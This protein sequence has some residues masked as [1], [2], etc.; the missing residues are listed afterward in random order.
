MQPI[1]LAC[2]ECDLLQRRPAL[3]TGDDAR[4]RRC[5]A[6][7]YRARNDNLDRP[8]AFTF[9]AALLFAVA[10]AFPIVSLEVQ[11]LT[12]TAT[13]TGTAT[14]LFNQDMRLLG[15]LVFVT[16]VVVPAVQLCGMA[17][18][19]I[20]LKAGIVP[21]GLPLAL[22]ILQA[23]RPWGMIEVF[24]LGVLVS[25]VKLAGMASVVPGIALWTFGGV[26]MMIAAALASFDAQAIWARQGIAR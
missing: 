2:R 4:C 19:L 24:L 13:L 7:L 26:L 23:V 6:L 25:L 15:A 10:N 3:A 17:Y 8:L 18:L 22:R 12:T 21:S 20:P 11:G 1:L 14:A 16:T 5:D 9:A